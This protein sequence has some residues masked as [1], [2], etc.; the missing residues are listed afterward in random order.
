MVEALPSRYEEI[1]IN[2][3]LSQQKAEY[4]NLIEYLISTKENSTFK[5]FDLPF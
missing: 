2:P 4:S 1:K 5:E 3:L